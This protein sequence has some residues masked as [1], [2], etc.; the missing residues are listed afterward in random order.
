M[1]RLGRV[2]GPVMIG[3]SQGGNNSSFGAVSPNRTELCVRC[4]YCGIQKDG[5]SSHITQPAPHSHHASLGP[6]ARADGALP[7][8]GSPSM[9]PHASRAA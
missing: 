7:S 4:S 6:A 9:C 1:T 5:L 8:G 2:S 3:L